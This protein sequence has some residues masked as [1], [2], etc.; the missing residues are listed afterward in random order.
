MLMT[1]Q[2][3]QQSIADKKLIIDNIN[4]DGFKP[5]AYVARLGRRVLTGGSDKE[6]D[7]EKEGSITLKAG[8]FIMFV[9]YEKFTL[10]DK[11]AGH[12]GM[13]SYWARKG[14]VL[15]AGM[16]IDPL[17]E[18]HLVLGA[19]NASPTNITLDYLSDIIVIEFH[20]LK[21]A[22]TITAINNAAQKEGKIPDIDKD[23]IRYMETH[24][25]SELGRDVRNLTRSISHIDE[26]VNSLSEQVKQTNQNIDKLFSRFLN[27]MGLGI[28][29]LGIIIAIVGFLIA[30]VK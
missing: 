18:G 1:N 29:S 26:K 11:I 28:G 22:P 15:L 7:L 13:R 12:I 20:Q 21:V 25:L 6:I 23:F 16:H 10:T 27:I 2:D 5:I 30:V 17:W 24:S 3:I 9:T 8:D 14:L 4:D 19:Y